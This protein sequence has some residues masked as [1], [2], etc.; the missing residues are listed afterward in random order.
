MD[1]THSHVGLW[2]TGDMPVQVYR[3]L[4]IPTSAALIIIAW[5]LFTGPRDHIPFVDPKMNTGECRDCSTVRNTRVPLCVFY[6]ANP[7]CP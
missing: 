2:K 5:V 6:G 7:I 1:Q 3:R 4:E